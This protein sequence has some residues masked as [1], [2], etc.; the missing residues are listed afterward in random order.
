MQ[1]TESVTFNCRIVPPT[2]E[3]SYHWIVDPPGLAKLNVSSSDTDSNLTL[4][5]FELGTSTILEARI[6]CVGRGSQQN[7]TAEHILTVSKSR[8]NGDGPQQFA[9]DRYILISSSGVLAFIAIVVAIFGCRFTLKKCFQRS[10]PE[11]E[12]TSSTKDIG[13]RN[14][15][16]ITNTYFC[17]SGLNEHSDDYMSPSPSNNMKG[18]Y[19]GALTYPN[20]EFSND[21]EQRNQ[22]DLPDDLYLDPRD[23]SA[24]L[25]SRYIIT[26]HGGK[27]TGFD[28]YGRPVFTS[29]HHPLPPMDNKQTP[30]TSSPE[31]IPTWDDE[32]FY[33]E[34][35]DRQSSHHSEGY[36][37]EYESPLEEGISLDKGISDLWDYANAWVRR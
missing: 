14:R 1:P 11:G 15:D 20:I 35:L 27:T 4:S 37:P 6:T 32:L 10:A 21:I 36:P 33:E 17:G 8:T 3:V 18:V 24:N 19:P 30:V 34:P 31:M 26:P 23:K 5:D 29:P 13:A 12:T 22:G 16:G 2:K 28:A 9:Y 7:F 25:S